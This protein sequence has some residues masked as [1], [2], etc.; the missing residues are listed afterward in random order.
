MERVAFLVEAT[1]ERIGCLLNPETVELRRVA[2]V[3][4]RATPA[5]VVSGPARSD[6]ALLFHGGGVTEME[7]ELLFDV[8]VAGS[9]PPATD[10]RALTRALWNLAETPSG[11]APEAP[12]VRFIWGKAWNVPGVV[13]AAAERLEHFDAEGAPRRS[14]LKLRLRRVPEPTP[15]PAAAPPDAATVDAMVAAADEL[16]EEAIEVHEVLGE[17]PATPADDGEVGPPPAAERLDQLAA[18]RYGDPGFWRLVA[19]LNGIA[20]PLRVAAGTVLRLPSPG[21]LRGE[22]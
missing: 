4:T 15:A 6:D 22:R 16:P 19:A 14:W 5:G 12:V 13:T 7:L 18:E 10:V 3:S 1:G 11:P 17:G 2:G 20:D 21:A 9:D 8:G